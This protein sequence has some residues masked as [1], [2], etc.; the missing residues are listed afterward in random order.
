MQ[1]N[2]SSAIRLRSYEFFMYI[3]SDCCIIAQEDGRGLYWVIY[4]G[5][6]VN[7]LNE[8]YNFDADETEIKV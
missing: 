1:C 5:T 7:I 3:N 4:D 8:N 6:I 2:D